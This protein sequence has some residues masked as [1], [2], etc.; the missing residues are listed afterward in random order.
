MILRLGSCRGTTCRRL[1][2]GAEQFLPSTVKCKKCKGG[3]HIPKILRLGYVFFIYVIILICYINEAMLC[4]YEKFFDLLFTTW[5]L[6]RRG[7][8]LCT[9]VLP[10]IAGK[11]SLLSGIN[12]KK[13]DG[14]GCHTFCCLRGGPQA[15]KGWDKGRRLQDG[16]TCRRH[17][18]AVIAWLR[19]TIGH[20]KG[21]PPHDGRPGVQRRGKAYWPRSTST[22]F[23][24]RSS[25]N[26]SGRSF[27]SGTVM[28]PWTYSR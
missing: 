28:S 19:E 1:V 23:S 17:G 24:S 6:R 11:F 14:K 4:M 13:K 10:V 16:S 25:R 8:R 27:W 2:S 12:H 18:D 15:Q 3:T 9:Q 26:L 22:G 7:M 20:K 5:R 21:R